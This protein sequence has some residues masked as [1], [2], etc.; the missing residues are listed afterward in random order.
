MD[1]FA[2]LFGSLVSLAP[3]NEP[4]APAPEPAPGCCR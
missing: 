1:T 2:K 3:L 4:P